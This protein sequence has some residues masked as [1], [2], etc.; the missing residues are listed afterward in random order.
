VTRSR[1]HRG[2]LAAAFVLSAA[3]VLPLYV[4]P[5]T[6]PLP[7]DPGF[8]AQLFPGVPPL[9]VLARLGALLAAAVVCVHALRGV[10]AVAD[11]SGSP[12]RPV[13]VR[14]WLHYASLA[15]AV[16]LLAAALGADRLGRTAQLVFV[17]ALAL[18]TLLI[19]LACRPSLQPRPTA[20]TA[21]FLLIFA[22]WAAAVA[23]RSP[24]AATPV[25]T[26][27]NLTAFRAALAHDGNLLTGRFEPGA[28]DLAHLLLG[29]PLL[30]PMDPGATF[31]W[32]RATA[33]LWA[34]ASAVAVRRLAAR[35]AG[36]PA[37][38]VAAAAFLFSPAVIWLPQT[39]VPLG[40]ATAFLGGLFLG[41]HEWLRRDSPAALVGLATLGGL[42]VAF[43]HTAVPAAG[44]GVATAVALVRRRRTTSRV[45]AATAFM[46][47]AAAALPVLPGMDDIT[48]MRAQ[49]LERFLPWGLIEPVLLGQ[50]SPEA[51][52]NVAGTAP[53]A[54][55]AA[56]A[57]LAPVATARTALRLWGDV[58]LEPIA[59]V[60]A[61]A[62]GVAA[63]TGR[64]GPSGPILLGF[65][66]LSLLPGLT[67]S[68][69]RPSL[70]RMMGLAVCVPLLAAGGFRTLSGRRNPR[71][72]AA[73]VLAVAASGL[74]LFHVTNPR[75][76]AKSWVTIAIEACSA[77]PDA[78]VLLDY[79]RRQ[80]MPWLNVPEMAAAVPQRAL[81]VVP[82]AGIEAVTTA[83]GLPTAPVLVWSPALE[84]DD[85]VGMQL[86]ERWPQARIFRIHDDAGLS[87]AWVAAFADDWRPAVGESR[88][89]PQA[90]LS[91]PVR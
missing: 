8:V 78:C 21:G 11:V 3:W 64:L 23:R 47:L 4:P 50:R 42:S 85:D 71:A 12:R 40:L 74:V 65:L 32:M 70:I 22:V 15:M 35:M 45:V 82:Y 60:L 89:R 36:E 16:V 58:F 54:A 44:L 57:L 37:G 17:G 13:T 86:R 80:P 10:D 73:V 62:G 18:P 5:S 6:S 39:P 81:R 91:P 27:L 2:W 26:W 25:D 68:Y 31:T 51:I 63:A 7:V 55:I 33:F 52:R 14:P 20:A 9:W 29:A 48:R 79:H 41:F 1:P 69:D 83:S 59:I 43:G 77:D 75:L 34:F 90:A 87:S 46:A 28:S 49:Y 67:S 88:W 66:V 76:L 38:L 19:H 84:D 72:A 30:A 61:V 56:G 53:P 24:L